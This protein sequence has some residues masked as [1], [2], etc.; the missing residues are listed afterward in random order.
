ME[1]PYCGIEL[2]YEDYFGR[3]LGNDN[4]DK[5]GEIYKCPNEECESEIFGNFFYIWMSDNNN[6]LYE[7][8]PC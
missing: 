3:Y 1:C 8:Y 4:W 7:G 6:R 5:K 2:E